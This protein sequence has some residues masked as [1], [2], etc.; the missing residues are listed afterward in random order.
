MILGV[1]GVVLPIWYARRRAIR[2][3]TVKAYQVILQEARRWTSYLKDYIGKPGFVF[4]LPPS[5]SDATAPV[6]GLI[7]HREIKNTVR[8]MSVL[9]DNLFTRLDRMSETE[10]RDTLTDIQSY[11]EAL[12]R[13]TNRH[14]RGRIRY[15]L[16]RDW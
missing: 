16:D 4:D 15:F 9:T 1:T 10:L 6:A 13:D 3:E 8:Y 7:R 5:F 11:M 12:E 2:Q 14:M